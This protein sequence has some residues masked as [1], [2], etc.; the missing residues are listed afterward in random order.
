M[1]TTNDRFRKT[2]LVLALAGLLPVYGQAETSTEERIQALENELK[3]LKQELQRQTRKVEYQSLEVQELAFPPADKVSTKGDGKSLKFVSTDEKY[4]FQV[5][6]RLQAD[7]AFYDAD[8]NAFGDGTKIRRLFLD[9][10]GIVNRDWN[11]RFQ[12]DFARPGSGEAGARGIRDAW[13]QYTGFGPYPVTVGSFKEYIGLEHLTSG[14]YTTFIERGVTDLFSPDRHIGIGVGTYRPNWTANIGFFGER[15]EGDAAS[16]GDEGQD[17][18]ARFTWTPIAQSGK[19]LHFGVAGR[20]H[21]PNDSTTELRLRE[22]PESNVTDVRLIDTGV[23]TN[24]DKT[25][26][27]G[28][29]AATVYGPFSVQSEYL[30]SKVNRGGLSDD[31]DFDSW[32]IY[33]SW[34]LTGESRTYKTRD[35]VFDRVN[36]RNKD[37]GAWEVALRYSSADLTDGSVIGGEQANLTLGVNWYATGNIRFSANY[38]HLLDVD[39]PGSIYHGQELDTLLFRGQID[40]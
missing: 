31:V 28:L 5:G 13:L 24:V 38:L 26:T 30:T 3:A 19:V 23:L 21:E 15:P 12:Y 16:E 36:P 8:T 20:I 17:V 37:L 32:Y 35:A 40:F 18:A 39:R 14:L 34:F 6:G 25:Q 9:V 1:K 33:G 22:R 2:A 7:S 29:E 27:L 10:R 11:Y 4:S